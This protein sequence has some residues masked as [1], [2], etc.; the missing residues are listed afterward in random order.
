VRMQGPGERSLAARVFAQCWM[1]FGQRRQICCEQVEIMATDAALEDLPALILPLCAPDLPVVLW[2][3]NGALVTRPEFPGVA[4]IARKVVLDSAGLGAARAALPLLAETVRQ[5]TLAGDLSWTRLTRW[6]ESVARLFEHRQYQGRIPELARLRVGY[7]G[8]PPAAAFYLAA[9]LAGALASAGVE[10]QTSLERDPG[11]SGGTLCGVYLEG[12][13][14]PALRIALVAA[15]DTITTRADGL[16]Q[17]TALPRQ[18]EYL[19]LR[20]ELGIIRRDPVFEEALPS[21][22]RLALSFS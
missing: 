18:T 13:G 12:A 14:D 19:L 20:E 2:C 4:A 5:G 21:A 16:S 22:T 9:W 11:A 15:G 1:P 17:C 7:G 8:E 6:R 10:V 3:R